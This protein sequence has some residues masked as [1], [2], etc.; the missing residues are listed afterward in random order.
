MARVPLCLCG[1]YGY[2]AT[3]ATVVG[4]FHRAVN[5]GIQ[6]VIAAHANVLARVVNRAALA[7]DDVACYAGLAA[8]Y[9]D[10]ESFGM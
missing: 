8:T 7:D 5:E 3:V 2:Y 10:A 9:L 1:L 6:R 4:E